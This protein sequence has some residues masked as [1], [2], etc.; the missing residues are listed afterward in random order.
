MYAGTLIGST[1]SR[2]FE[3]AIRIGG[4]RQRIW[5]DTHLTGR[6]YVIGIPG[7]RYTIEVRNNSVSHRRLLLVSSVDGLD[8]MKPE[9]AD[10]ERSGGYVLS[11]GETFMIEGAR[12]DDKTVREFIFGT[13]TGSVA[14]QLG[15]TRNIGVI[16]LACFTERLPEYSFASASVGPPSAYGAPVYRG[17]GSKGVMMGAEPSLGTHLGAEREQRVQS[18]DFVRS[19][20]T[21]EKIIIGYDTEDNLRQRGV[22]SPALPEPFPGRRTGYEKIQ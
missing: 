3:A 8:T 10:L 21:P 18:V 5:D 7:L 1:P 14:D 19:S 2:L 13:P 4:E 15:D 20:D 6:Y 11:P 12:L 17:G 9:P 16:G 22:L